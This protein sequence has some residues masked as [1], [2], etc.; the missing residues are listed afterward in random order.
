MNKVFLLGVMFILL[1]IGGY[2]LYSSHVSDVTIP[3]GSID[4][5]AEVETKEA[6]ATTPDPVENGK[7]GAENSN[8]FDLKNSIQGVIAD[9]VQDEIQEA[10]EKEMKKSEETSE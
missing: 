1:A 7:S 9:S 6:L 10:V 2:W 5:S 3:R 4:S 8:L